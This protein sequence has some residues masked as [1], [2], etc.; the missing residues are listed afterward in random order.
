VDVPENEIFRNMFKSTE[1]LFTVKGKVV[2]VLNYLSTTLWRCGVRGGI[3]PPFFTSALD[4]GEYAPAA[5]PRENNPLHP[6]DRRLGGPRVSLNAAEISCRCWES[7]PG[8]RNTF[9]YWQLG[10]LQVF[11]GSSTIDDQVCW[12][13]RRCFWLLFSTSD[14][15]IGRNISHP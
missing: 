4:A 9:L 2:P 12:L 8:R 1:V 11:S 3:A 10:Y 13:R 5:L 6:L 14:S 7:N 15:N